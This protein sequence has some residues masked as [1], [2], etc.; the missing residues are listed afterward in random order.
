M[1]ASCHDLDHPGFNNIFMIEKK[2]EIAVRY[3]DLSVLENHHVASSFAIL[4][5]EEYNITKSFPKD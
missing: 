2:D 3:N 4:S 5:E 1:A